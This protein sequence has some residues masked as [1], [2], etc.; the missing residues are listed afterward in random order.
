MGLFCF[1]GYDIQG[2]VFG[3]GELGNGLGAE[4]WAPTG[5]TVCTRE[6]RLAE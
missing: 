5:A 6:N 4:F 3:I 1:A 2:P